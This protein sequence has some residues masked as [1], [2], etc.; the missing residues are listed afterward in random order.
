M[1][2]VDIGDMSV[3]RGPNR[4]ERKRAYQRARSR[5]L[6]VLARRYPQE[7]EQLVEEELGRALQSWGRPLTTRVA[8]GDDADTDPA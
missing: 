4:E 3:D 8:D 6:V 1:Q 7:Y 5:A 2:I